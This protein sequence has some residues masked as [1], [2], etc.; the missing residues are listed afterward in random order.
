M[1]PNV[2]LKIRPTFKTNSLNLLDKT[3]SSISVLN[4]KYEST[5]LLKYSSPPQLLC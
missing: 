3:L 5:P 2:R 1:S 4:E